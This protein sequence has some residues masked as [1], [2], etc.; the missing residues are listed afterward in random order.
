VITY[1]A[2]TVPVDQNLREPADLT[3]DV[4]SWLAESY[5]FVD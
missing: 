4:R 1:P 3:E 2:D 5:A